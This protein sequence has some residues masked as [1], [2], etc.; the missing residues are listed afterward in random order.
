MT[1]NEDF[2][3]VR[4]ARLGDK[5]AFRQ[6]VEEYKKQV[7]FIAYR[8]TN[9]H[10]D[11]DDLSQEAFVKAYQSIGSFKGKSSFFTWLYRITINITLNYLK[12]AGKNQPFELDENISIAD[13]SLSPDKVLQQRQL[14]EQITKA[15][16]SLP[17]KEKAV[18]ELAV[19]EGLPHKQI[20]QILGCREK[21]ASWRLFQARKKLKEKLSSFV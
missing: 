10:A 17:V 18:V 7:Y 12:K 1:K 21:T 8:M 11:A 6:L 15:I 9:N 3:L 4:K 5:D 14:H 2:I 16:N 13:S 19:L 20:A